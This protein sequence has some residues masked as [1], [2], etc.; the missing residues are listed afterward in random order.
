LLI[1]ATNRFG[2]FAGFL[3]LYLALFHLT[4]LI[5]KNFDYE[6]HEKI[7]KD[8][9]VVDETAPTV[10]IYLPCCKEPLEILENT[11]KY[12][13]KMEY[14][15]G[16]LK[17]H[18]LDD[19]AMEEVKALA[20]KYG[21]NYICRDDRPRLKKAGNLRWAFARTDGEYFVIYD[22]DFCPRHDYLTELIP[23]MRGDPNIAIIQTPQ[24][25]R[26]LDNQTW[27]ERGA[28]AVQELFY[29]YIQVRASPFR[30]RPPTDSIFYFQV[31]RNKWGGAICV[32]SNAM[33]RREALAGT[34]GTAEVGASEDVHTGESH[35]LLF[36]SYQFTSSLAQVSTQ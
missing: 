21:F 17:V 33:Y 20:A 10:D 24:Y 14:P 28:G 27:V 13:Q 6:L 4:G 29:R 2:L 32:G 15:E 34:G 31:N 1:V 23:R 8:Y 36:L 18:V 3:Q 7:K 9:A 30:F 35:M 5:S 25:F 12:V 11:Y 16:R 26:T 22:A 19:G